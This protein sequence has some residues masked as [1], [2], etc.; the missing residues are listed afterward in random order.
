M[1]AYKALLRVDKTRAYSNIELNAILSGKSVDRSPADV[2]VNPAF[3]RELVYGV[4]KNRRYLDYFIDKLARDGIEGV[5]R[6]I[7]ILLRMGLYQIVF[8]DSVPTHSAV[9]ETVKITKLLFPGRDGFVNG[10]LR[11]FV[12]SY[13]VISNKT[14]GGGRK[15]ADG[16]GIGQ[17]EGSKGQE[18]TEGQEVE[19]RDISSTLL[20]DTDAGANSKPTRDAADN[21]GKIPIPDIADDIRRMSVMYSCDEGLVRLIADQYGI[22]G[23]EEIL[24]VSLETPPL[25]IRV[26]TIKTSSAEL[27]EALEAQGFKA[28]V[29]ESGIEGDAAGLYRSDNAGAVIDDNI[30]TVNHVED[31]MSAL[32]HANDHKHD[33]RDTLIVSGHGILE[34]K[35]FMDG[36]FFVQDA[37]SSEAIKALDPKAGE[38]LIDVCAAPGG[39]S[40]AAAM[41]MENRGV[42]HAMDLHGNKLRA[43]EK[44][45]KR[46][47][48]TIIDTEE[49][50]AKTVNERYAAPGYGGPNMKGSSYA[51]KSGSV[52][53]YSACQGA[54]KV[55]CDV[56]CSGLG[57]LRRKP[58]IKDRPLVNDGRDLAEIQYRILCSSAEYVRAGG[59]LM[60]GTCTIN[61]IENEGVTDRFLA[62][63]EGFDRVCSRLTMPVSGGSDGFYYCIFRRK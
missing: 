28:A 25:F 1:T 52:L 47:G 51:D 21:K 55:L 13:Y 58:E 12:R 22:D 29:Y 37:S 26:N 59:E 2:V 19:S 16:K 43:L 56:P 62:E 41:L 46:L 10:L 18:G 35:E 63:H 44:Q 24:R 7:V 15:A 5:R 57:V 49:H 11:N 60:Y 9:D 33:S 50:D 40:F 30:I 53:E 36:L 6:E 54:V 39:K 34:T 42:I 8:M 48:I 32:N 31:D 27:A 4:I 61:K 14:S 20:P 45:A 23:A 3:V 17:P 38:V